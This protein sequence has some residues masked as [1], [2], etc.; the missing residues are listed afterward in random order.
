M[1]PDSLAGPPVRLVI[2]DCDGV[3]VD[4]EGPSNRI[5]AEEITTL[6]WP[7]TEADSIDLFVGARLADI[8]P[9]V[10]AKLGR[11]VPDTWVDMLRARLIAAFDTVPTIPG[12]HAALQAVTAHGLPF[13]I[14][15]NSSHEE[16]D[17]KF[18]HTGLASLIQGRQHSARD[19]PHGK[20][21]PDV[22]L[23]AAQAE[24]I[25]PSACL[26]IEDSLPGIA[27][28]RAAGMRVIG[29]ETHGNAI[30]LRNAGAHPIS[31]LGELPGLLKALA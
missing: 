17:A 25:P 2:F 5:V 28:A 14:A 16:M 11:P 19:V 12:A 7:I 21:A 27:A 31:T 8:A 30:I 10:E 13:R 29:L 9:V 4:S 26:V 1:T 18:H 23:H 3:L 15:S 24:G 22:F 6:G 20:P